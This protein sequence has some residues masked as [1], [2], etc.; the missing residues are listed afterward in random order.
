MM[1]RQNARPGAVIVGGAQGSLAVARSLGRRGIPVFFVTHDNQLARFSRYVNGAAGWV[2]PEHPDAADALLAIGRRHGLDG[3]LL[4]PGGDSEVRFVAEQ[5]AKLASVYRITTPGW[6][7]ARWALDKR[8]TY[9]RAT[10]LAIDHP[11]SLYPR[12]IADIANAELRFPIILKP[13]VRWS[14]NAFTLAKAWRVDDRDTLLARCDQAFSLVGEGGVILQ[15]MIPGDGSAQYSYAALWDRGQPVAALVARRARQYPLEFGY[16]STLVQTLECGEVEQ[17]AVRF[18][19]S[20]DYTGLVEVE[21][22]YDARDR[23]YK[24]LDVNARNWTWISLGASVGVDFPHLL[25]RLA[26]GETVPPARG[27]TGATWVYA[28][29]DAIA[30]CQLIAARKLSVASFMGSLRAPLTF[31]VFAKDDVAPFI[32]ELP[33][34]G[35]RLLT[36]RMPL[37]AGELRIVLG[38]WL[39]AARARLPRRVTAGNS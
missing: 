34:V 39:S 22:K 29:R 6:D 38:R 31:A 20:L 4:F 14:S 30:A 12:S 3:Y 18:L 15:E 35:W 7:T 36:R 25:W 26:N 28:S 2:G 13:A 24:L 19:K 16:S 8:L 10:S 11:R 27:R 1:Q 17:A 5:H 9:E 23:R 37:L 21:F 33:L 32:V